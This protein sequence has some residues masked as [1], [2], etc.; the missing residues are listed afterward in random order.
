[1]HY[2]IPGKHPAT[3]LYDFSLSGKTLHLK[4]GKSAALQTGI[5]YR[6]VLNKWQQTIKLELQHERYQ[7]DDR[8]YESSNLLIPSLNL[9]RSHSDDPIKP[10][11]GYS[12]NINLQGSPKFLPSSITF[13]QPQIDA[14]YLKTFFNRFPVILR[15]SLGYTFINDIYQ[16]PLSLQFYTGGAQSIR[17]YDY[18]SIGPGYNLGIGS[19]EVRYKLIDDWYL[20]TFF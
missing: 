15:A 11:N 18:N 8:P 4:R 20:A 5:G 17:G 2:L 3:D 9:L 1:M 16:L 6:S 13:L 12:I 19:V 7:L 10:N 14:K